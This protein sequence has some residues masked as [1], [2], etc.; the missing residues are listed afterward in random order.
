VRVLPRSNTGSRAAQ[1]QALYLTVFLAQLGTAV[2]VPIL[3]TLRET[4]GI[5]VTA[6]ALTT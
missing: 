3:P 4:F 5:S 1:R 6:V 2:A